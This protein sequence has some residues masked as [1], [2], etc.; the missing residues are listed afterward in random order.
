MKKIFD[1]VFKS[2]YIERVRRAEGKR[3]AGTC[4]PK[5]ENG[6]VRDFK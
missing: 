2:V 5:K 4:N 6:H 1:T 3:P